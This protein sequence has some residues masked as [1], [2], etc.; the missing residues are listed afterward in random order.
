MSRARTAA[1]IG[2]ALVI[3]NEIRGIIVVLAMLAANGW[4]LPI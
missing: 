2:I 1:K 3:A 4:R